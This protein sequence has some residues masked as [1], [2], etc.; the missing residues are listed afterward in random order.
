MYIKQS[1]KKSNTPL[2]RLLVCCSVNHLRLCLKEN[3]FPFLQMLYFKAMHHNTLHPVVVVMDCMARLPLSSYK[4]KVK[5]K[6]G[7]LEKRFFTEGWALGWTIVQTEKNIVMCLDVNP[8]MLTAGSLSVPTLSYYPENVQEG[9]IKPLSCLVIHWAFSLSFMSP[10]P[11]FLI[12]NIWGFD[13]WFGFILLG[14]FPWFVE[15]LLVWGCLLL[16][17]KLFFFKKF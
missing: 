15:V 17:W 2:N 13:F 3:V 9:V 8:F 16:F 14:V 10:Q 6:K 7:I 12:H 5:G 1:R 11:F 4:Q